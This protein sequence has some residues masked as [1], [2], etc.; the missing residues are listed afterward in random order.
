MS[1][2]L[3]KPSC[4]SAILFCRASTRTA[5]P[6]SSILLIQSHSHSHRDVNVESPPCNNFANPRHHQ[7]WCGCLSREISIVWG[8]GQSPW[9]QCHIHSNPEIRLNY[10]VM[11]ETA[12]WILPIV[13]CA[14][15]LQICDVVWILY[16]W[17]HAPNSFCAQSIVHEQSHFFYWTASRQSPEEEWNPMIVESA[18]METY[19]FQVCRWICLAL[20]LSIARRSYFRFSHNFRFPVWIIIFLDPMQV[21]IEPQLSPP[22]SSSDESLSSSEAST[23]PR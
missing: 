9:I 21:D 5:T 2:F 13:N 11:P 16:K 12:H 4:F 18:G 20:A 15:R 6:S 14:L 8:S 19:G 17:H 22:F 1:S 23:N 7:H 3:L 10:H